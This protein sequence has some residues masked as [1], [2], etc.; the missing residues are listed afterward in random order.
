M[1]AP[2]ENSPLAPLRSAGPAPVPPPPSG[3]DTGSRALAEALRVSF[4][5]L[6]VVL[7][8]LAALF[9]VSG[10]FTLKSQENAVILRFGKPV[11][12]GEQ[13]LLGP[14]AHWAFPEPIDKVERVSVSGIQFASST[15]GW[16]ATT[17]E[18]E[19]AKNEP[20]PGE[21]LNPERDG[22]VLTGDANI[23]HVR[24]TLRYRINDPL[25]YI[26][27]FVNARDF[28][29]NALN[30]AL[31]WAAAQ[32]HVDGVLRTNVTLF[33]EKVQDRVTQLIERQQLGIVV[34]QCDVRDLIPPRKLN[35]QFKAVVDAGLT[36]DTGRNVALKDANTALSNARAE[37]RA[38]VNLGETDRDGLVKSVEADARR[39]ADLLPE[40]KANPKLFVQLRQ[41][42]TLRRVMT[43]VQE[44]LFVP[45]RADGKPREVRLLLNREQVK[46]TVEVQREGH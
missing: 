13:A 22:Y 25:R 44:K 8:A 27:D 6:R 4:V 16:Y 43:N 18:A 12:Q 28:V 5:I 11:G 23:V 42:E 26:F 7:V 36:Q 46:P 33:R 40:F 20:P 10:F 35:D 3:E 32:M 21:G 29:T 15:V 17:P 19:A 34:E 41:S 37:A 9:L 1:K 14:G 24:A 39:F 31:F 30:N 38:R 45:N 2:S